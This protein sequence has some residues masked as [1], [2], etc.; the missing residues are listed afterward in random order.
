MP[1]DILE[2]MQ[3][4]AMVLYD[5]D[6]RVVLS[7]TVDAE[8]EEAALP[9]FA[10]GTPLVQDLRWR[11]STDGTV[12]GVV[13][14]SGGT[15][16]LF[17]RP[18]VRSDGS[19]PARGLFVFARWM[20]DHAVEALSNSLAT[21]LEFIAPADA[22]PEAAARIIEG[23]DAT[24]VRDEDGQLVG[25]GLVRDVEGAPAIVVRTVQ[26][27]EM[28]ALALNATWTLVAGILATSAL[29]LGTVL[30][31]VEW[32]LV[33]PARRLRSELGAIRAGTEPAGVTM[34]EGAGEISDVAREVNEMLA[35]L[36]AAAREEQRLTSAMREQE[37]LAT[38]ALEAMTEGLIA[39]DETGRCTVC[40]RSAARLL[41]TT[42]V[43]VRGRTLAE[44]LPDL[45]AAVDGV[46][47]RGPHLLEVGGRTLAVSRSADGGHPL[48]AIVLRD[49]TDVLSVERLKRDVISTVSHE[50]RTPLTSIQATVDLLGASDTAN[51]TSVQ[52][53]LVALLSRNV[54]RLGVI[55]NDLL[56]MSAL[57]VAS[58]QLSRDEFD[59][60]A[61]CVRVAEDLRAAADLAGVVIRVETTGQPVTWADEGRMR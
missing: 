50:L 59:L 43:E 47:G 24:F 16:A 30:A 12:S 3:L 6:G 31:G 25:Y 18:V 15:M 5:A 45:H 55:V 39:F 41:G 60:G 42:G 35:R 23:R 20:S 40:N 22:A 29:L 52:Q 11:V 13:R 58:V 32:A 57:E 51:F 36:A 7:R 21:P 44:L 48:L 1:P 17:G 38:L 28:G 27:R 14:L 2:M 19:G 8:G 49:V 53:H 54:S 10:A 56:T 34:A 46:E 37:A 26:P 9:E 4:G 33:R 61:L